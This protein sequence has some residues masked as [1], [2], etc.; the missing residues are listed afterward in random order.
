[1]A[2]KNRMKNGL[3]MLFEDNFHETDSGGV[4]ELRISLIEPDRSQPRTVFD[5]EKLSELADNIAR[6]GVLQPILVRPL[7]NGSY[8]IV[9]GERRWRAARMAGLQ[10]IPALVRELDESEAAQISLIENLQREDLDP[11][12]EA[13]AYKRLMDDFGMTQQQL[14][15]S[16]GRSRAG[17]ANSTRMLNLPE[18]VQKS[19]ADGE[20]SA[21]H[22]KLLCGIEDKELCERLCEQCIERS[23]TVRGLEGLI[24]QTA[25][26]K[27]TAEPKK[28][29]VYSDFEKS[30]VSAQQQLKSVCGLDA[31]IKKEGKK[32]SIKFTFDG[33]KELMS[34]ISGFDEK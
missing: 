3:D 2:K 20:V 21:G 8:R 11:I 24:A 17:I 13:R 23:L 7:E 34:F 5:E 29:N 9:A 22:A 26:P 15:E 10:E 6:H 30:A 25:K 16:L 12:E 18:R 28:K 32:Y 31:A 19:I 14:A 27:K 1:M 33:E 4:S